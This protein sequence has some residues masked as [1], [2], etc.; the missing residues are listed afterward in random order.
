MIPGLSPLEERNL[1]LSVGT[2]RT[3]RPLSP[4]EVGQLLS[5]AKASGASVSALA[6]ACH[7]EGGTWIGRF[8]R[9]A[10]LSPALHHLVDWGSG[11]STLSMTQAQEIARLPRHE[12]QDLLGRR[13]I[14]E[15]IN[16]HEVRQV[17]QL[18]HRSS[19]SADQAIASVIE[20]RPEVVRRFVYLATIT[21]DTVRQKLSGRT[22]VERNQLLSGVLQPLALG[23]VDG[24]LGI[25]RFTLTA[26]EA[27]A[28]R[29]DVDR[30]EGAVNEA[31]A[32]SL[33]ET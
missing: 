6:T 18:L 12:D 17:V 1:I 5:R 15:G 13:A 4:V 29:I 11:K 2:H 32:A 25:D 7:L 28:K 26:D 16:S 3:A 22:Q 8:I 20:L 27:A 19:K 30:V 14:E 33:S 23:K 10:E 21:D 31:L 9:L 24:R